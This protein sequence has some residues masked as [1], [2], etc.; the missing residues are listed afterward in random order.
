M[1]RLDVADRAESS[2]L[3]G[4]PGNKTN[5]TVAIMADDFIKMIKN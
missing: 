5:Q 1:K 2:T 3:C 4:K